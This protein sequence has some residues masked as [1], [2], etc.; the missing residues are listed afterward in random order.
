LSTPPPRHL[1]LF[2]TLGPS[3]LPVVVAQHDKRHANRAVFCAF[4]SIFHFK[5]AGF[6]GGDAK[7]FFASGRR[8]P[9]TLYNVFIEY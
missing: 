9:M 6:V 7:V 3:S 2:L 5:S 4:M 1:M 8:V